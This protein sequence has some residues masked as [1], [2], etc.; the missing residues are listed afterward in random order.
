MALMIA[1]FGAALPTLL[2]FPEERPV[3][4][5]EFSTDHY[6][7]STYF[8]SRLGMEALLTGLQMLTVC[9]ITYFMIDFE[10]GFGWHFVILYSLSMVSTALAML[11]GSAVED[12][13]LAAEMLPMVLVPQIMFSGFF[14]A[15]ELIPV[16]LRWVVSTWCIVALSILSSTP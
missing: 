13:Q 4:V 12:P 11:L 1:M 3:F 10:L 6:R 16:W 8:L 5:R 2:A 9:L 15:T 14:I 7:V